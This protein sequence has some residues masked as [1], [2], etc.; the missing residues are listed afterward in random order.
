MIFLSSFRQFW[1]S[2]DSELL[3][4]E[5]A[6]EEEEDLE[7]LEDCLGLCCFLYSFFFSLVD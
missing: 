2:C 6:E 5:D 1:D 7:E 4:L 3:L